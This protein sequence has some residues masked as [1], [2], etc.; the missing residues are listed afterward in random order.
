MKVELAV[1]GSVLEVHAVASDHCH[2]KMMANLRNG[3]LAN[4]LTIENVGGVASS[5][6]SSL[7]SLRLAF[8]FFRPGGP[9]AETEASSVFFSAARASFVLGVEC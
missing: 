6:S 1:P 8:A 9:A 2:L 5:S 4:N 7:S 3:V